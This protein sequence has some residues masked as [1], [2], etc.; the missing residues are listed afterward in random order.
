MKKKELEPVTTKEKELKPL[1]EPEREQVEKNIP[2]IQ[3]VIGKSRFKYSGADFDDML[4]V[5][6]EALIYAVKTFDAS[7]GFKFSTYACKCIQS[8]LLSWATT[9][10]LIGI[11]WN[12]Y[13]IARDYQ[14]YADLYGHS[15]SEEAEILKQRKG[16]RKTLFLAYN[17]LRSFVESEVYIGYR[18]KKNDGEKDFSLESVRDFKEETTDEILSATIIREVVQRVSRSIMEKR[19]KSACAVIEMLVSGILTGMNYTELE[20]AEKVGTSPQWVHA[21]KIS[22]RR[23]MRTELRKE[24]YD[25]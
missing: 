8:G 10:T 9:R 14:D 12:A 4:S 16:T 1:T 5:G 25:V 23:Q 21:V 24:G 18:D 11:P 15:N 20:I 13:H 19:G 2:L 17:A 22:F 3:Y 6:Y 7:L